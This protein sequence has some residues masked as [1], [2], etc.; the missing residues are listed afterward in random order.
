MALFFLKWAFKITL[1]IPLQTHFNFY[2]TFEIS[3]I[4]DFK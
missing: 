2:F 3:K 1:D 4:E